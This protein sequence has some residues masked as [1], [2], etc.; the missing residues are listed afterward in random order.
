MAVHYPKPKK[1]GANVLTPAE[2]ED[3]LDA[4]EWLDYLPIFLLAL[5]AGLRQGEPVDVPHGMLPQPWVF[6][7][8]RTVTTETFSL[9]Q[10]T[11]YQHS[12]RRNSY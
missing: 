9:L 4:A 12:E 5:T 10:E 11:S 2:V 1:V 3:Y 7:A 8:F 6:G